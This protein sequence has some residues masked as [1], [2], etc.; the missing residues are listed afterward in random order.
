MLKFIYSLVGLNSLEFYSFLGSLID[1][2]IQLSLVDIWVKIRSF[3]VGLIRLEINSFL[4]SLICLE[5]YS[6][7]VGLICLEIHSFFGCLIC[8]KILF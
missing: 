7:L 3:L 5:T 6:S 2:E 1:L 4:G 8:L